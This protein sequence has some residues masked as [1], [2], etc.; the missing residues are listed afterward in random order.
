MVGFPQIV[1]LS[2]EIKI[3]IVWKGWAIAFTR[4]VDLPW[5]VDC[6]TVASRCESMTSLFDLCTRFKYFFKASARINA[7]CGFLFSVFYFLS[8]VLHTCV[9]M[10]AQ[11]A[12]L[13]CFRFFLGVFSTETINSVATS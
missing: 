5:K 10:I 11:G 12:P 4:D 3:R 7:S 13:F 6:E 1:V 9:T 2:K 8:F